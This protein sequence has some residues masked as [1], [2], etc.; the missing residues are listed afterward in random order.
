MKRLRRNNGGG[1][2]SMMPSSLTR[3]SIINGTYRT[4]RGEPE[5]I[6][7]EPVLNPREVLRKVPLTTSEEKAEFS[8]SLVPKNPFLASYCL[9]PTCENDEC[10]GSEPAPTSENDELSKGSNAPSTNSAEIEEC[11]EKRLCVDCGQQLKDVSI[12]VCQRSCSHLMCKNCLN[13]T[14]SREIQ[15]HVYTEWERPSYVSFHCPACNSIVSVAVASGVAGLPFVP[16]KKSKVIPEKVLFDTWLDILQKISEFEVTLADISKIATRDA[17]ENLTLSGSTK[18]MISKANNTLAK[19]AKAVIE[20]KD[21][22]NIEEKVLEDAEISGFSRASLGQKFSFAKDVSISIL[23][24]L[25]SM[26]SADSFDSEASQVKKLNETLMERILIV[27]KTLSS[28]SIEGL[29]QANLEDVINKSKS[30]SK[31]LE[32]AKQRNQPPHKPKAVIPENDGDKHNVY[33]DD[34]D[35]IVIIYHEN[36]ED[37]DNSEDDESNDSDAQNEISFKNVHFPKSINETLLEMELVLNDIKRQNIH[38]NGAAGKANK[39][40]IT[41]INSNLFI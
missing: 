27:H 21:N 4:C 29:F 10:P 34:D 24:T 36:D 6:F 7:N 13:E 11:K 17:S 22:L 38:V 32:H 28:I 31:K 14:I 20:S 9:E 25:K 23:S 41:D 33:D 1:T 30:K 19:I 15:W 2:S 35:G 18:A 16:L 39:N 40:K 3:K 26:L 5:R 37:D 12:A 8:H